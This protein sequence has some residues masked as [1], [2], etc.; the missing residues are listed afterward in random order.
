MSRQKQF[1]LIAILNTCFFHALCSSAIAQDGSDEASAIK[2]VREAGGLVMKISGESDDLEVSFHIAGEAIDDAKI[3]PITKISNIVWLNLARTK[4]TDA[5]MPIVGK[6]TGLTKLH[7][8][9]SQ[10]TNAGLKSLDRLENLEYLNLYGTNVSDQG[11]EHLHGLKKLRKLY[12]WQT[13]VTEKG[14]EDLKSHLPELEI[15]SGAKMPAVD[16]GEDKK[17]PEKEKNKKD[18]SKDDEETKTSTSDN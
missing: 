1:A 2:N 4:V 11:L 6:M 14:I 9:K 16:A 15:V 7:L 13:M 12:V 17:S 8:E 10:I 5:S 3:A 18:E